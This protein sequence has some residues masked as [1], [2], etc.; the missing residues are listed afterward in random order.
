MGNSTKSAESN[1]IPQELSNLKRFTFELLEPRVMLSADPLPINLSEGITGQQADVETNNLIDVDSLSIPSE[2]ASSTHYPAPLVSNEPQSLESTAIYSSLTAIA[3]PLGDVRT[4]LIIVDGGVDDIDALLELIDTSELSTNYYIYELDEAESGL[5]QITE[6]VASHSQIDAIHILSHGSDGGLQLGNEWVTESTLTKNSGLISLWAE[7]LDE[8]ADLL[9]YGCELATSDSGV[10]FIHTLQSLTQADIAAS[11]DFT[12]NSVSQADW[13]LEYQL[14]EINQTLMFNAPIDQQWSGTLAV[15]NV[16]TTDDVVDAGDGLLSLREAVIAANANAGADSINLSAGTYTLTIASAG[17]DELKE[18]LNITD[19]LSIVGAGAGLTFIDGGNTFKIAEYEATAITNSLSN[20]TLQN[21]FETGNAGAIDIDD[22]ATSLT[23]TDVEIIDS[24]SSSRGGAIH[25]SGTLILERVTM[26]GNTGQFGG[27]IYNESTGSITVTNSTLSGNSA[28]FGGA[29]YNEGTLALTNVTITNNDAGNSGGGVYQSSGSATLS[30]TIIAGNTAVTASPDAS[31]AFTSDGSNIIGDVT[32][33]T[34]FGS[35]LVGDPNLDVLA[36][37][38]GE[39]RTHALLAGSIAIDAGTDTGAPSDDQRGV[40]RTNTDIGAYEV[41]VNQEPTLSITPLNPSFTEGG[42]AEALFSGVSADTVDT[43]QNFQ[44]LGLTVTNITDG[45]A[46]V[47]SINGVLIALTHLNTGTVSGFTYSVS[48][49]GTT[50]TLILSNGSANNAAMNTLLSSMSYQNTSQDPTVATRRITLDY[51]QDDGGS[52]GT[53]DNRLDLSSFSDVMV[54]ADNDLAVI[55]DNTLTLSQ[56]DTVLID[57]SMLSASDVD[58]A[59]S[60]IRFDITNVSNGYFALTSDTATPV[61][62]FTQAQV[63]AATVVFIHD[64]GELAPAYDVSVFDGTGSSIVQSASINFTGTSDGVIWVSI[65]GDEGSGNGIPGLDGSSIDKGDILQ[66]ADPNFALGEAGTDGTFSVAFDI[67][68]YSAQDDINGLHY[69][70]SD[71]SI[72]ATNTITLQEGDLVF[73]SKNTMTLTSNGAGAPADLVV[74]KEDI[75][76]FRPDVEGDYSQGNFYLLLS[77]PF[78]DGAEVRGVTLI[79]KDVWVGDYQ[80]KEGD[81]LFSRNDSD[82]HSDIWLLKTDTLDTATPGTYPAML[83]LIDGD[84]AGIDFDNKIFSIDVLESDQVIGGQSYD[85]GTVFVSFDGDDTDGIGSNLQIVDK[86]DVVALSIQKTTLVAGA[87][88]TELTAE[89]FFDGSDPSDNDVNFDQG[90][91]RIDAFSFTHDA[92][93]V[94]T[95]PTVSTNNFT[96]LEGDSITITSALLSAT[97][98]DNADLGLIYEFS[99][100]VGGEFQLTTNL[101]VAV[102]TFTQNQV[103][104]NEV[105]FVDDGD[106]TAPSF[107]FTVSDG[108]NTTAITPAVIAF[109]LVNDE[110]TLSLTA[111]NATFT[112][113]GSAA[114]IFS[115]ANASTIESGDSFIGLTLTITNITDGASEILNIDGASIALTNGNSGSSTGFNYS[116]SVSGTTATVTLSAGTATE[117]QMNTLLDSI[118]YQN[119]DADPTAAGRLVTLTALQD[120][121]GTANSGDDTL[122]PNVASTVT[123]QDENALPVMIKNSFALEQGEIFILGNSNLSATDGDDTDL[124]LVYTLSSVSGGHFEKL[125]GPGVVISSFTQAEINSGQIKFIDDNDVTAPSFR[126]TVSDGEGTSGPFTGNISFSLTPVIEEPVIEVE[127]VELE[128]EIEDVEEEAEEAVE[129]VKEEIVVLEENDENDKDLIVQSENDERVAVSENVTFE[130]P[131]PKTEP[132]KISL[133]VAEKVASISQL[134]ASWST[135]ADPLLLIKSDRFMESLSEL[136]DDIQRKVTL[137]NMVLGSGAALSTGLSVGYVA[138]LL[139][140]G[141][142]LTSVLSSLP[143]WRFIDPLPV[144]SRIGDQIDDDESLED[145]VSSENSVHPSVSSPSEHEN[146]SYEHKPSDDKA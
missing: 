90:S 108:T 136:D 112:E 43:G 28:Q 74:G 16:T 132:T 37:N 76:Y 77:D 113:G 7:S 116:V 25:N 118:S 135:L 14:G 122:A 98:A 93:G 15:Y 97:D 121:G 146:A 41:V 87:G 88:N 63:T 33:G 10:S 123:V 18:H 34:G 111:S 139:R 115:G 61:T 134:K 117:A 144:L 52:G 65:D 8:H 69:V 78:Q 40:S 11:N 59:D 32:G 109:T 30:N 107:S 51:I 141:I 66:Q 92:S 53:S 17:T 138:W 101:G 23:I 27:A 114:S 1:V 64:G 4:E 106:E 3:E 137:D 102:T 73:S 70:S 130:L 79:E 49:S 105:V 100:I 67:S 38:G 48:L 86:N 13:E 143:A 68:L 84:E 55:G 12:G 24:T 22:A 57:A 36:D 35:D 124:S 26:A 127:V 46:E 82:K 81:L 95:P 20:L 126:F 6:R 62:S 45:S 99:S 71:V 58:N 2:L 5:A 29:I 80:L 128:E 85:A 89:I 47:M 103:N 60:S 56:G 129:S 140:S 145:I 110:P 50:A 119:N 125:S 131:L 44:E 54:N 31:G 104:N 21:G 96:L 42:S 72:G 83:L 19:S 9:L 94:N 39:T 142:V 133:V 75:F 91:E 120:S